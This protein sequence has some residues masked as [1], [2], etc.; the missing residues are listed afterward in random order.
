MDFVWCLF[1]CIF[2]LQPRSQ[3]NTRDPEDAYS[4]QNP[5]S[6]QG[7]FRSKQTK[8]KNKK[9]WRNVQTKIIK[10]KLKKYSKY[11]YKTIS[12]N[13]SEK[14]KFWK[15]NRKKPNSKNRTEHVKNRSKHS[16]CIEKHLK[17]KL[18]TM[19]KRGPPNWG[20]EKKSSFGGFF[21]HL[22]VFEKK[23]RKKSESWVK[24][25]N[26]K[27][28]TNPITFQTTTQNPQGCQNK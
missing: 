3:P 7:K 8:F 16:E 22:K 5:R 14:N 10:K 18:K 23:K 11:L 28:K 2:C 25:Q 4:P 1:L 24:Q 13:N 20:D 15:S 12:K 21:P 9:S 27:S 26:K 17:R 6:F 19:I